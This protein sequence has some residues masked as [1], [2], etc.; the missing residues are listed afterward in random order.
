[1]EARTLQ[2]P[3]ETLL[4]VDDDP[5]I[6]DLFKQYMTR[7]GYAVFA[8]QSGDA[9]LRL[10]QEESA[11]LR[12]VITDMTMPGI[13]GLELA[14]ALALAA[15]HLPVLI[16]TGHHV[17]TAALSLPSNVVGFIQKPYKTRL[18]ADQIRQFLDHPDQPFPQ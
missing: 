18:F 9:G 17:D 12:L 10:A 15:P 4:I 1:M 6:T 8:A 16:A 2:S 7:R 14:A 3:T 13:D 5:L 11:S